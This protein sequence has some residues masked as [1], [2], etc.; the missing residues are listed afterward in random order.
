[1]KNVFLS[2][3]L[4]VG[5]SVSQAALYI[6]SGTSIEGIASFTGSL[7]YTATNATTATLV[8]NLTN[9]SPLDNGGYLTSFAFNNPSN[10]ITGVT[11]STTTGLDNLL[12]K[13]SKK[14]LDKGK[15][16]WQNLVDAQPFGSFDIGASVGSCWHSCGGPTDGIYAG[17]SGTWT[18]NL[19]GT[20]LNTLTEQSFVN[21][22]SYSKGYGNQFM[23]VRFRGFLDG[24]SDKVPTVVTVVPEPSEYALVLS[25]GVGA[26]LFARRRKLA[27]QKA[28]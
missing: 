10:Y 2:L 12:G 1:M 20:N 22:T 19:T 23:V 4:L 14:Q 18:F 16:S 8:V 26:L 6:E 11:M 9:T 24:G 13:A 27:Q 15:K 3:L 7:T 5:A 21:T 17:N 28:S 25:A